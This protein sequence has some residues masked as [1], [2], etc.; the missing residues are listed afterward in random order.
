MPRLYPILSATCRVLG[1]TVSRIAP[2]SR[3]LLAAVAAPAA[4]LAAA[5]PAHAAPQLALPKAC[6][7]S[8][9]PAE[10]EFLRTVAGGFTPDA[11]VRITVGDA[12]SDGTANHFG[13]VDLRHTAAPY[14]AN[15]EGTFSVTITE[16][17]NPLN[18][19]TASASVTALTVRLRPR[20]AA[21]S[22]R[23]RFRG[24][25][26]TARRAIWAHYVLHGHVRKTV[27][28]ARRPSSP[29]GA[30]SVRRRQIPLRHPRPGRWTLQVDQQH[31][32]SSHPRSVFVP[33]TITVQ[34]VIGSP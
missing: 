20:E 2:S 25:G 1:R 32:W 24:R 12:T 4:L 17:D 6:Y 22:D 26:F 11:K 8:V 7:V 28:L 16:V 27:R 21:T 9:N 15:G 3:R 34:R 10:R 29:C 30:F 31:R 23:V 14:R 13:F 19:V 18:T 33:V 5:V